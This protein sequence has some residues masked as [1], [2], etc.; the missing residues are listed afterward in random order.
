ME[1]LW[2]HMYL[3]CKFLSA[4]QFLVFYTYMLCVFCWLP[5]HLWLATDCLWPLTVTHFVSVH[6]KSLT[7]RKPTFD[8]CLH[9]WTVYNHERKRFVSCLMVY[10]IACTILIFLLSDMYK[11]YFSLMYVMSRAI[12]LVSKG[13]LCKIWNI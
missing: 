6:S 8:P 4:A 12:Q 5:Y 7:L 10:S 2:C 9:T 1:L 13:Y 3:L 11:D